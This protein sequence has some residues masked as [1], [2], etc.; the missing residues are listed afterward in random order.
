MPQIYELPTL[1]ESNDGML[2]FLS[3]GNTVSGGIL[4]PLVLLSM[5][6]IIFIT[7]INATSVSRA[8]TTASLIC[9]ILGVMLAVMQLL[10]PAYMYGL[11]IMVAIGVVWLKLES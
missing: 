5:F 11:F 8:W 1:N 2:G 7:T 6:I 9:A 3:Y 4:F 10:A